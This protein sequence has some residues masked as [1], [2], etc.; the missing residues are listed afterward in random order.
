MVELYNS[1]NDQAFAPSLSL[2]LSSP[3]FSPPVFFP[4]CGTLRMKYQGFEK[5][6]R[7][8]ISGINLNIVGAYS[9]KRPVQSSLL[10][11]TVIAYI[12]LA[13]KREKEKDI[14]KH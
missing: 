4:L 1:F 13:R 3:C 5:F 2:S 8:S 11:V 14:L 10:T 9:H 12:S 7:I 6:R